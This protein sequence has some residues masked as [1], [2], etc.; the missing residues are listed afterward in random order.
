MFPQ[1]AIQLDSQILIGCEYF[2]ISPTIADR[3]GSGSAPTEVHHQL[4]CSG[5]IQQ[6]TIY[7]TTPHKAM[8]QSS[9]L[10]FP[11]RLHT[12][13]NGHVIRVFLKEIRLYD[14]CEVSRIAGEEERGQHNSLG[15][16]CCC[17]VS[18]TQSTAVS[19]H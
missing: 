11:S 8:N 7:I 1:T 5:H 14:V 6:Q 9:L 19:V 12:S 17:S 16:L 15:E 10:L 13:S 2:D 3:E 18:L 4:L